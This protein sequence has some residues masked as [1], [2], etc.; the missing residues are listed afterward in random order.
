[1]AGGSTLRGNRGLRTLISTR[2]FWIAK[3]TT[4]RARAGERVRGANRAWESPARLKRVTGEDFENFEDFLSVRDRAHREALGP[5]PDGR[6]V[7]YCSGPR[8]KTPL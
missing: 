5:G 2:A 6:S 8:T 7:G 1:M 3:S 4:R